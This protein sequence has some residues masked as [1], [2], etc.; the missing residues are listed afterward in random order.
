MT[1]K[2]TLERVASEIASKDLALQ[3]AQSELESSE[4]DLEELRLK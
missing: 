1:Y 3:E 4:M 2:D